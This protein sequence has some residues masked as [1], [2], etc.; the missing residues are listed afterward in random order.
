MKNVSKSNFDT[1]RIDACLFELSECIN[2]LSGEKNN[3][4][5][6][7]NNTATYHHT[8]NDIAF[9]IDDSSTKLFEQA[10]SYREDKDGKY[11]TFYIPDTTEVYSNI[12]ISLLEDL[13][14]RNSE[15]NKILSR[16]VCDRL[17]LKEMANCSVIGYHFVIGDDY[18][19]KDLDIRKEF[20]RIS[21]NFSF[22]EVDELVNLDNTDNYYVDTIRKMYETLSKVDSH[23]CVVGCEKFGKYLTTKLSLFFQTALGKYCD[24]NDIPYISRFVYTKKQAD[25]GLIKDI[26][27][28]LNSNNLTVEQIKNS[29]ENAYLAG[30]YAV[31]KT[32]GVSEERRAKVTAPFRQL[33]SYIN[34]MVIYHYFVNGNNISYREDLRNRRTLNKITDALNKNVIQDEMEEVK[35]QEENLKMKIKQVNKKVGFRIRKANEN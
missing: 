18:Q 28:V 35:R 16:K 9:S 15:K 1:R 6:K 2:R 13:V 4:S 26:D 21:S 30:I 10:Y 27:E 33:P 25:L 17:N 34:Q 8:T 19:V 7:F 32:S 29:V 24:D 20:I 31:S 11:L 12:D 14:A 22:S 3:N 5:L 23:D